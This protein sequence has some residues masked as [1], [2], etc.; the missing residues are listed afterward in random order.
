MLRFDYSTDKIIR[1]PQE[2]SLF[3]ALPSTHCPAKYIKRHTIVYATAA[4]SSQMAA[5]C[6]SVASPLHSLV[7]SLSAVALHRLCVIAWSDSYITTVSFD[8]SWL[9]GLSIDDVMIY[10]L[11]VQITAFGFGVSQ[12]EITRYH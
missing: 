7:V 2:K 12:S 4:K 3:S 8:T 11:H 9:S 10:I 5:S 6:V 1:Y